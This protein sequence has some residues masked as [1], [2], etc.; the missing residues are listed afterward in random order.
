LEVRSAIL[1]TL[2]VQGARSV[3]LRLHK[4]VLAIALANKLAGVPGRYFIAVAGTNQSLSQKL[5]D[6]NSRCGRYRPH[7]HS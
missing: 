7:S 5:P 1:R 2:F 4:N 6:L 3:L